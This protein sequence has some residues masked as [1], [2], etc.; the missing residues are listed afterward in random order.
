MVNRGRMHYGHAWASLLPPSEQSYKEH[1][2]WWARDREGNIRRRGGTTNFCT[3]NP[4][5]LDIVAQKVNEQLR[6]PEALVA[7]LDPNDGGP[8]CMCDNCLA[9]DRRYGVT[10]D[11]GKQYVTDRL[12]HFSKEI[13]DRLE[14][15]N[16]GKFLGILVY[17]SA[18]ELPNKAVPH[19]HHTGMVCNMGWTYDHTRPFTDPTAPTGYDFYRLLKGWGEI[20][21]Q[22]GYYDYYGHW[23]HFG[24]WGQVHKMRED[25]PA[26]RD[27]GGTYLFLE[28]QP[29]FAMHGLNHYI[30][31]RLSW[32]VDADVDVLLEEF[33]EKFYG[34]AA[35]PMRRFWLDIERYYAL[36]RPGPHGA[37]RVRHTPGMWEALWAH[38][39]EARDIL[40]DL[41]EDQKRFQDRVT[42]TRDGFDIAW[43]KF[44]VVT[45]Y[46]P[47][48]EDRPPMGP[49]EIIKAVDE[50][51]ARCAEV[52][53]K[54]SRTYFSSAGYW[55]TYLPP[56][57]YASVVDTFEKAKAKAEEQLKQ[58][59]P[60]P[61]E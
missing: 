6:N 12:L 30:A 51:L 5:V 60:T 9:L 26:F 11:S 36:L 1:P 4:E 21:P 61:A 45:N 37:E 47:Q 50:S 41:P 57:Y 15:E 20:L 52:K 25:L 54:Y 24:P 35:E 55:P 19:D 59:Q 58:S 17:A 23:R 43:R 10:Q 34:P 40:A 56:Y 13:Y 27:V 7:S 49:E 8:M 53:E 16:K 48:G 3:T 22:F 38:L 2:E 33:F 29:N 18:M 32:D 39:D 44:A 42:F 14:P 46:V 28:C 31:G